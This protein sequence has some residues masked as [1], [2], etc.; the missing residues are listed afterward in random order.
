MEVGDVEDLVD[1]A[2]AAARLGSRV[3]RTP[4]MTVEGAALGVDAPVVL[5]LEQVQH[6]GSFKVRGAFNRLLA[7]G[8]RGELG[9]AGVVA[10]SG[11]NHGLGVA[12][13]AHALAYRW[14]SSCP[15]RRRR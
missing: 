12:H 5:K 6:T 7:A 13:A 9:P 3:R 10:A 8:G 4:V 1:I 14:R 2:G 11:G 15:S